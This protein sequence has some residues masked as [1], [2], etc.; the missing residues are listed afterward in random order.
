MSSKRDKGAAFLGKLM[1]GVPSRGKMPKQLLEYTLEHLFGDVWQQEDLTLQERSLTTCTIL[2]AL[3]RE[4]EQRLHFVG[5][6]NLGVP[7]E[8]LEAVITHAAHYAGWPV[9]ASASRVLED[10]WP[11]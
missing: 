5:A 9:A 10:V 6:R 3:G 2:I 11:E 4:P 1:E 8:K 7:R